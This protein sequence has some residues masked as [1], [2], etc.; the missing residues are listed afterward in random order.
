MVVLLGCFPM[1]ILA[2][3]ALKKQQ[4]TIKYDFTLW[5]RILFWV[6]L[7]L[8]TIVKTKIVHYSSMTYLPL[9]FLATSVIFALSQ[10]E[11]TKFTNSSTVLHIYK[12]Y[13]FLQ[14]LTFFR[15]PHDFSS[16]PFSCLS[17]S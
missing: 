17:Y 4:F 11:N 10:N 7:L 12:F 3:P 16:N 6:V 15:Q 13:K 14:I 8:F 1:S 9:S 5:M 2:L